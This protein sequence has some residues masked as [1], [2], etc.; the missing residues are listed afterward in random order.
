M[1]P[2]KTT[3]NIDPTIYKAAKRVA[4]E[5]DTTVSAMLRKA[6]LVLVSDPDGVDETVELLTDK[7]AMKAIE[8][9]EEAR[10]R[11]RKD[12]YIDWDKIRDL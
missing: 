6:L 3:L 10:R 2:K 11:G 4:V 7:D 9:G 8:A 1:I 12:H 5:R